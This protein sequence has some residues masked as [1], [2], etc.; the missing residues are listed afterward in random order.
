VKD[1]GFG[2]V[3]PRARAGIIDHQTVIRMNR[4]TLYS[5]GV[6]DLDAA[7]V[8]VT[9]PDSGKRFMSM[10]VIDEDQYAPNVFYA[11]GRYTIGKDDVGTRYVALAIRTFVDPKSPAD[12]DAAHALR[13]RSGEQA[14]G[15]FETPPGT[16]RR[17]TRSVGAARPRGRER[18]PRLSRVYGRKEEVDGQHLIGTAAGR[19]GSPTRPRCGASRRRERRHS[20]HRLTVG[21]VPVDGF[22][23]V[24]FTTGR[25][26]SEGRS[27]LGERRLRRRTP[28][29]RSRP[30]A[31]T[32]PTPRTSSPS[33]RAG[34]T[35]SACRR[36]R[37]DGA[38]KVPDP[39]S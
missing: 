31:A 24:A 36:G 15:K 37:I 5:V 10:Q 6:F 32:T 4:D 19:G 38:W 20:G 30:L 39:S 14:T 29:A 3:P 17:S 27:L 18:W 13:T 34:T 25:V 11:P 9:L 8:T 35:S 12:L 28:T 33:R 2:E 21:D 1:G 16:N 22:W 7:P 23:S 26:T